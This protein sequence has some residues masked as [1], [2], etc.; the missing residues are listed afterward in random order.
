[1]ARRFT[2]LM[3]VSMFSVVALLTAAC[4]SIGSSTPGTTST[5]SSPA[6]GATGSPTATPDRQWQLTL[7]FVQCLAQ[8]NIPIW[9]KSDGNQNVAS[10]GVRDG[11]YKNGAVINNIAFSRFFSVVEGSYPVGADFKPQMTVDQWISNATTDG[12]W[13]KVC[14]SLPPAS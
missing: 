13:P 3:A 7:A 4:G 8:H 10:L 11:W 14:G 12:T 2:G 1:M 6:S 9:D 5:T